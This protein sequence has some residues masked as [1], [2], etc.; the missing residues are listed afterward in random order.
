MNV[1]VTLLPY[2]EQDNL[3]N[4]AAAQTG[5]PW[6]WDNPVPG[7]PSGSLRT[8]TLKTYQCPSDPSLSNGFS[9]YQINAWAGA[10][11]AFNSLVIG[12]SPVAEPT[13]GW[14]HT[15]SGYTVGT[16]PDGT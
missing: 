3:Y 11:Y 4:K 16:I 6:S 1:L 14:Y 5:N 2:V 10:S 15:N 8:Q 9:S 7:T 13:T 12:N